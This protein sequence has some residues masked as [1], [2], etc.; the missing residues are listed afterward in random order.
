MVEQNALEALKLSSRGYVL[1]AGRN[2]LE[3]KGENLLNDPEVVR[4]YL[5]G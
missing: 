1:A 5:G 3:D 4:R 2:R